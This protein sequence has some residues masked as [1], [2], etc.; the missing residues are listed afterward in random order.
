MRGF[1]GFISCFFND[2][3]SDSKNET[4][5]REEGNCFLSICKWETVKSLVTLDG[6]FIIHV[7]DIYIPLSYILFALTWHTLC[8]SE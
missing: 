5:Y 4:L 7:A 8:N 6:I 1:E 2:S 3:M